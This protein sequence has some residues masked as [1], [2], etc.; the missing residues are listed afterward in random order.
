MDNTRSPSIRLAFTGLLA[1]A[2]AACVS[3]LKPLSPPPTGAPV[4]FP[5]D[6]YRQ[7]GVGGAV[8]QIDPRASQFVIYVYR[9]GRLANF[10]HDHVV[11]S[12]DAR[13][14]LLFPDNLAGA[15]ADLYFP[16]AT[17]SVDEAGLRANAGFTTELSADDIETTRRRMLRTVLEAE[18]YPYIQVHAVPAP[19]APPRLTLNVDLTLHGVTRAFQMPIELAVNGG[20]F[21]AQG[22]LDIRQTDFDITPFSVLNGALAVKDQLHIVFHLRGER[23]GFSGY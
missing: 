2:L 21:S 17:L 18:K 4:T 10:G 5:E 12:H 14:Y 11:A 8:Y 23:I 19:G 7:A 22:E 9:D 1:L 15:R 20:K 16:V 13:G 6:V 3:E